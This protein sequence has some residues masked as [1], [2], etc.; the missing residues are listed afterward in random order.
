[1]LE[2]KDLKTFLGSPK[3]IVITTHTNPDADALGS[4]LGLRKYLIKKGH[5]VTVI[6]PT[7]YPKFLHWMEGNDEVVI[8][9]KTKKKEIDLLIHGADIIFC[10]DFNSLQ[11][12]DSMENVI[13]KSKAEKVLIDHHLDPEHFADYELSSI[14]AAATAE[15]IYE[16][17]VSLGDREMID[18]GIA[19]CLYAGIMTDTG[20]FKH[21]NVTQNVHFVTANLMALG[22]DTARVGSLI[23][24]NNS[25]DR[26]KFLGY[27]LYRKLT[28]LPEYSTAYI[29]LS[30]QD[31]NKF[32]AE[33]GDM[34]GL[35][36]YALSL[37]DVVLAALISDRE[38]GVKLS[39]RSKGE[40][41]VNDFARK[42]FSGG[43][44]K[45]AAGGSSDLDIEETVLKFIGIIK[46]YR[47]E[48]NSYK[49][50]MQN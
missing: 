5:S 50:E 35:V 10:L 19:E 3:N 20:Q 36:N 12:I 1:M 13:R 23:Y 28:F 44:H 26:I 17:I 4:S 45:N 46:E 8:F 18:K 31:Q 24:D 16:F 42:H 38:E 40:F 14:D 22:A 21:N 25:I 6:S 43:G 41:S 27:A 9:S 48:L 49:N 15:L 2:I 32:N 34:E 30:A 11:R 37:N 39:F 29:V 33:A 47:E 7:H